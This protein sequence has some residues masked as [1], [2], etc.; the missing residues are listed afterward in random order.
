MSEK[1]IF[2]RDMTV[3]LDLEN[4]VSSIYYNCTSEIMLKA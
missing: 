4:I 2:I 3:G 1:R